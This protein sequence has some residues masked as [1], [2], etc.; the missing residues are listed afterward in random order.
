MEHKQ[1]LTH[2]ASISGYLKMINDVNHAIIIQAEYNKKSI[3]EYTCYIE[4][5][6]Q[7]IE[8]II[9]KTEEQV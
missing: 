8:K 9:K 2:F 3:K 6:L 1:L 5:H 7:E 4:A